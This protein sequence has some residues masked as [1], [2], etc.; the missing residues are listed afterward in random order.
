MASCVPGVSEAGSLVL[1]CPGEM[2][3]FVSINTFI[4]AQ[5]T[6]PENSPILIVEL[7]ELL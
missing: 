2:L 3:S 5:S 4:E 1:W 6:L 7:S